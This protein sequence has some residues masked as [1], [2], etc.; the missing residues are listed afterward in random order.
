MDPSAVYGLLKCWHTSINSRSSKPLIRMINKLALT[1]VFAAGLA[2]NANALL[3]TPTSSPR[4]SGNVPNNINA[5][6]VEDI[7]G[8]ST[9]L[10]LL[11]KDNVGG[12]EEGPLAGSYS[13]SYNPADEPEDGAITYDGGAFVTGT[14]IYLVI[15][16]GDHDPRWYI[17]DISGW[18]GKETITFEDFWSGQGAISHVGIYGAGSTSVPDAGSSVAL[19]GLALTSLGLFRRKLQ[20]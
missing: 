15:K 5:N 6:D 12:A 8:T 19:L 3:I 7:T 4:W 13:T 18:N 16:D 14:P 20:S 10:S 9:E 17:F 1:A 2:L 11:Y